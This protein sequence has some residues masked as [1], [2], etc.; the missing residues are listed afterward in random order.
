MLSRLPILPILWIFCS[1]ASPWLLP[2]P[3]L[4]LE[5]PNNTLLPGSFFNQNHIAQELVQKHGSI[6]LLVDPATGKIED[7]NAAAWHFYGYPELLQQNIKTINQLDP[8]EIEKEM[9]RAGELRHNFFLFR[10]RLADGRIRD[11]E[12]TSYPVTVGQRTLLFSIVVDVTDRIQAETENRQREK[13]I[14]ILILTGLLLQSFLFFLLFQSRQKRKNM[15]ERLRAIIDH[16]PLLISEI[17]AAGRYLLCNNETARTFGLQKE[18]IIGKYF[19]ELLPEKTAALFM[20][21]LAQIQRTRKAIFVEDRISTAHGDRDYETVL[22]PLFDSAGNIRSIAGISHN[23]TEIKHYNR[24]KKALQTQLIDAHRMEAIGMLASGIAH[25]FNNILFP[26]MGYAEMLLMHIPP[27]DPGHAKLSAIHTAALRGRDL[28][29]QILTFARKEHQE[30]RALKL[31]PIIKEVL[32]FIRATIPS[33]IRIRT[34]IQNDCRPVKAEPAHI[35]QILMNLITNA[36]H[37]METAGGDM[38]IHLKEIYV[39]RP[40]HVNP[41]MAAGNYI[42]LSVKDTGTG[43]S[44]QNLDKIFQSFFT[45]KERGKGT[46]MGLSVVKDIVEKCGGYI[47]VESH[48][49]QGSSFHI[50]LPVTTASNSEETIAPTKKR[51]GGN[52][53]ILLVDDEKAIIKLQETILRSLGYTVTSCTESSQALAC[54]AASPHDFDLVLTDM[55]MPEM[56]G[57][58]LAQAILAIRPRTPILISTGFSENLT[59]EKLSAL[60]IRGLLTKPVTAG[61]LAAKIR[62]VLDA[63]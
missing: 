37:A 59:E 53:H 35:H 58:R 15:E 21:R 52:E 3:A 6:M 16:S 2:F 27:E 38:Q 46:G 49:G 55:H 34:Y 47:Q 10:H 1:L 9:H 22:F 23:V 43:I 17:S 62:Q 54:F 13:Q 7:A 40:T 60:G 5:L 51:Q 28:T 42:R 39:D 57:D 32:K 11:V 45:T 33:S 18:E 8:E 4:S 31:Q 25:D 61:D 29:H 36:Y 14:R 44:P 20:H 50:Y 48:E 56:S 12:V 41:T 63:A 24:E 30:P 26:I 19:T